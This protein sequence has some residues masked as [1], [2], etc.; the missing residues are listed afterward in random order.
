MQRTADSELH[1]LPPLPLK[2]R[3]S[4]NPHGQSHYIFYSS[5]TEQ[6]P[7]QV[8]EA[9]PAAVL[10]GATVTTRAS[11]RPDLTATAEDDKDVWGLP[12][13]AVSRTIPA[14]DA[15]RQH[16]ESCPCVSQQACSHQQCSRQQPHHDSLHQ[17]EVL[18]SC[19]RVLMQPAHGSLHAEHSQLQRTT[20]SWA[21]ALLPPGSVDDGLVETASCHSV[22]NVGASSSSGP[23]QSIPVDAALPHAGQ[24]THCPSLCQQSPRITTQQTP[25]TISSKGF[26]TMVSAGSWLAT[27]AAEALVGKPASVPVVQGAGA[28]TANSMS[29]VISA[30]CD[31]VVQAPDRC[32]AELGVRS[33]CSEASDA[34]GDA[35]QLKSFASTQVCTEGIC[36]V[37]ADQAGRPLRVHCV[38]FNMGNKVPHSIPPELLGSSQGSKGSNSL[39]SSEVAV[40]L[41][42]FATQVSL[43]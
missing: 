36:N 19:Q 31:C 14:A 26:N 23:G 30:D 29:Q 24:L 4:L 42:V 1:S 27:A 17:Q 3:V 15:S 18:E 41:Y 12:G 34:K 5:N 37:A 11:S 21:T 25:V 43:D 38:T 8:T 10:E 7:G 35:M 2:A 16:Q 13:H 22:H 9:R 39:S 40:D 28:T 20:G 32:T 33:I 6:A